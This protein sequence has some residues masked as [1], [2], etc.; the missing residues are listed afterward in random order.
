MAARLAD[1]SFERARLCL[2]VSQ[3]VARDLRR[4]Y[5]LPAS[6]VKTLY[7]GVDASTFR[8]LSTAARAKLR[9]RLGLGPEAW[10]LFCGWNW[11]RK[12]LD[13]V[14]KAMR[15][16]PEARLLVLG[17]DAVEGGYF[18]ALAKDLG[19]GERVRFVGRQE[20]VEAWFGAAD[21]FVFPTRYEPFGMVVSEAMASGL[22]L[23]LP[24][25]AGVSEIVKTGR[26]QQVFTGA[27]N[28][29]ALAK[30]WRGLLASPVKA[31][32]LGRANRAAAL[33]LSWP[34]HVKGLLSI[35]RQR[36][37]WPS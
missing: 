2:A 14:F 9:R 17:E 25:S 1:R 26:G 23:L 24:D 20:R 29:A 31:R 6:R 30:G 11:R 35:Y 7:M 21:L 12:G 22:P 19:L 3:R 5:N 4:E 15:A 13:T 36:E 34:A 8:P 32:A 28:A 18:R 37:S 27:E 10:A 16:L 33:H